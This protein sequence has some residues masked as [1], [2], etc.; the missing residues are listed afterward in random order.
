MMVKKSTA[1]R[2][3][4]YCNQNEH[5]KYC[6][7]NENTMKKEA[8]QTTTKSDEPSET[9]NSEAM[10]INQQNHSSNDCNSKCPSVFDEIK[11]LNLTVNST[12]LQEC[13]SK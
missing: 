4:P 6:P 2:S 9:G 13:V 8:K 7:Q 3:H 11:G 10:T 12:I 1:N 5:C